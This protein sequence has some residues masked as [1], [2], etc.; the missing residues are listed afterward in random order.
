MAELNI[1]YTEGY[2]MRRWTSIIISH[3]LDIPL[4]SNSSSEGLFCMTLTIALAPDTVRSFEVK[5][6]R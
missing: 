4:R 2:S 5:T 6:K 3:I 1:K